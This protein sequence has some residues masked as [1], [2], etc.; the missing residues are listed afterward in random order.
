MEY[1]KSFEKSPNYFLA[2]SVTNDKLGHIGNI[3]A[4]VDEMN[5]VADIGIL[6]GEVKALGKGY[7]TE[8]WMAICGYLFKEMNI[9]KITAG[10]LSCNKR[11]LNL[12]KR[13][14]MQDDG[15]RVKQYL[16]EGKEEDIMHKAIFKERLG[17][18]Y[19]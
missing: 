6:I 8:A 19:V 13:A 16:W 1:F 10:T 15:R 2:I 17:Q 4:Y 18:E 7:A 3:T 9:R 5:K 14:G 12:M 11:M